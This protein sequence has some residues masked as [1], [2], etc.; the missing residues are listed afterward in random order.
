[1]NKEASFE[2]AKGLN[3]QTERA[4]VKIGQFVSW[5]PHTDEIGIVSRIALGGF[6]ARY[7]SAHP[8]VPGGS[9]RVSRTRFFYMAD[10]GELVKVLP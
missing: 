2:I 9:T 1:M 8:S 7:C 10:I 4:K 3:T 6:W 5:G